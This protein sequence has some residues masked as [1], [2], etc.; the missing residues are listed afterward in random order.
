ME[1]ENLRVPQPPM[2]QPRAAVF[3]IGLNKFEQLGRGSP[4][5]HLCQIISKSVHAVVFGMKPGIYRGKPCSHVNMS[6]FGS[7]GTFLSN[8][9]QI[10]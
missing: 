2:G 3:F 10:D 4:R 5:D 1:Q 7:I 8:D 9:F 6:N